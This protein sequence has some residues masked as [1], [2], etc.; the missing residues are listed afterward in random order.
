MYLSDIATR[1][2]GMTDILSSSYK[3][4][5]GGRV[6]INMEVNTNLIEVGEVG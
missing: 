5:E 1:M 4:C 2:A 3:S 6:G